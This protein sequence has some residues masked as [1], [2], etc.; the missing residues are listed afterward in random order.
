MGGL[1]SIRAPIEF[2]RSVSKQE[3][4]PCPTLMDDKRTALDSKAS[5]AH[6]NERSISRQGPRMPAGHLSAQL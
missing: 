2:A 3:V 5:E 6:F 4:A 1:V